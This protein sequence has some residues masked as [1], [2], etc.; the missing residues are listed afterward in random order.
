MR[1]VLVIVVAG[2]LVCIAGRAAGEATAAVAGTTARDSGA[3]G[4]GKGWAYVL[5]LAAAVLAARYG[6]RRL[7]RRGWTTRASRDG[8]TR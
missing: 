7:R 2:L 8:E 1:K 6:W 3:T 4:G 5:V